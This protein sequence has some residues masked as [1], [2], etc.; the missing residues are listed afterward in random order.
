[1]ATSAGDILQ[2]AVDHPLGSRIFD[3]KSEDDITLTLGGYENADDDGNVSTSG[4]RIHIMN[5]RGWM[6]KVTVVIRDG[7][8]DFLQSLCDSRIEGVWT[9][10]FISGR[11]RSGRGKPS[12]T[13]EYSESDGTVEL[14]VMGSREFKL[15]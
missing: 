8:Q 1:M 14:T 13:M 11:T 6:L 3:V 12:G 2:L 9:A 10:S 7:D 5:R 4:E 15:Q